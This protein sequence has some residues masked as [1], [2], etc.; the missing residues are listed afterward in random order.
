MFIGILIYCYSMLSHAGSVYPVCHVL[1][2]EYNPCLLHPSDDGR[3]KKPR[4]ISTGHKKREDRASTVPPSVL[5]GSVFY[6]MFSA[7]SAEN[8]QIGIILCR[9]YHM[10]KNNSVLFG[11]RMP[12]LTMSFRCWPWDFVT[13]CHRSISNGPLSVFYREIGL[14]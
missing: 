13:F 1:F 6:F 8:N 11:S 4:V 10:S 2:S 3:S 5:S 12:L 14:S 7:S 9:R